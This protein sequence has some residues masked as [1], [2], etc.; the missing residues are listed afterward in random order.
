MHRRR[1]SMAG[2]ALGLAGLMLAGVAA[3]LTLAQTGGA[4]GRVSRSRC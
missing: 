4:E 3:Q 2:L 1:L